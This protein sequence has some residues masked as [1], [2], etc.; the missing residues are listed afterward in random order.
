MSVLVPILTPAPATA[1]PHTTM[2]QVGN[3]SCAPL[4]L[5]FPVWYRG[6]PGADKCNPQLTS[7]SHVWVIVLNIIEVILQVVGYSTAGFII[8]GGIRY[9]TS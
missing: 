6:L 8:W 2:A 3:P 7:T 4:F 5:T 1:M 9:T